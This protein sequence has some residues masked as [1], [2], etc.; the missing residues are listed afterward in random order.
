MMESIDLLFTKVTDMESHQNKMDA[1]MDM[2]NKVLEQMIKD[3]E[4]LSTQIAATGQAVADLRMKHRDMEGPSSPTF[5]D[6]K[7]SN[8]FQGNK[9]SQTAGGKQPKPPYGLPK[10]STSDRQSHL[11]GFTPKMSFPKFSGTNPCIW[12]EKCKDCFTLMETPEHLWAT[13]ASLHMEG[14]A[15]K[16]LHMHKQKYGLGSWDQFMAA[17]QQKFGTY[18]YKHAVD[19]ILEL[20]Q[21][22]T[23]HVRTHIRQAASRPRRT[24]H[25]GAQ[26]ARGAGPGR[27]IG[28]GGN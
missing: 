5:S 2:S 21:N 14:N 15:E 1:K 6:Y 4:K 7:D 12:R 19:E 3:Q 26:G 28:V 13:A 23:C 10:H 8:P 25:P 11:R 9:S 20:K 24:P 16:W 18:E 17:V 27:S 22:G